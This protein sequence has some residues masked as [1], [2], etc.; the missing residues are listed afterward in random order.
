LHVHPLSDLR[1]SLRPPKITRLTREPSRF[2][3]GLPDPQYAFP[4][5]F[6]GFKGMAPGQTTAGK[7]SGFAN[8][9]LEEIYPRLVPV[10]DEFCE[11]YPS[12]ALERFSE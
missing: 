6:K 4:H 7:S 11:K 2:T 9:N 10:W 12:V 1:A 5:W 3:L 8:F